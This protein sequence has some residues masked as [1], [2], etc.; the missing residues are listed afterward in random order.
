[1]FR[2]INFMGSNILPPPT[3]K[4]NA[5]LFTS[6]FCLYVCKQD[7]KKFDETFRILNGQLI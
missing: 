2:M 5:V 3:S 4:K 6:V 7:L 1:M